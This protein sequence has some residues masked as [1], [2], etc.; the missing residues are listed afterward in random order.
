MV[1]HEHLAC[2]FRERSI[3]E[4]AE[5]ELALV[6]EAHG[7]LATSEDIAVV[8]TIPLKPRHIDTDRQRELKV[9]L[10]NLVERLV[11]EC[12]EQLCTG[13]SAVGTCYV[14]SP[15]L[16]LSGNESVA[17]C[18]PLKVELGVGQGS[19]DACC[20]VVAM[21]VLDPCHR[22]SDAVAPL[23]LVNQGTCAKL[24][25]KVGS[26][27]LYYLVARDEGVDNVLNGVA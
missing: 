20:V 1:R 15:C 16:A 6:E 5:V 24:V 10:T 26:A 2:K 7:H 21:S 9:V 25:L 13:R 14:E 17:E 11:V 19:L 4:T 12:C 23:R 22:Q 8:D 3:G 27:L 18:C